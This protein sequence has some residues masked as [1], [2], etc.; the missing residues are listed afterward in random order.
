[1]LSTLLCVKKLK[2]QNVEWLVLD[3]ADEMLSM[4]FKDDLDTILAETPTDKQT[5]LFSATMPTGISKITKQ[6]MNNP[7]QIEVAKRNT[8]NTDVEHEYYMV[9]ARDRYLAVKRLAD[10]NPDIY[11]IIFCRTRRETKE[12]AEK[13]MQDG[14]NADALHVI[15]LKHNVIT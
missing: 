4:G 11:G 14:Y 10:V 3:E 12:V 2:L 15:Y 13:L 9:S 5:L 7:T 6:Y 1:M 8:G